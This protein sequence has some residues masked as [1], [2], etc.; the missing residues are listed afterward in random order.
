[1]YQEIHDIVKLHNCIDLKDMVYIAMLVERLLKS[2]C[3]SIK[4]NFKDGASWKPN[5][6]KKDDKVQLKAKGDSSKPKEN[7]DKGKFIANQECMRN[8]KCFRCL[9]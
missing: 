3:T 4:I 7:V 5:W 1:M 2:R 8:I 6:G 9:G